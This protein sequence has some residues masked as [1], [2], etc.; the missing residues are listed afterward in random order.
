[1]RLEESIGMAVF[2]SPAGQ[3]PG[4]ELG[5]AKCDHRH[6]WMQ[7]AAARTTDE[8]FERSPLLAWSLCFALILVLR[9]F[10]FF[11][12]KLLEYASEVSLW[13]PAAAAT[14]ACFLVFGRRAIPALL[15]AAFLSALYDAGDAS[16]HARPMFVVAGAALYAACHCLC[17]AGLAQL[18]SRT[19]SNTANPS[20]STTISAFLVG[21]LPA[22]LLAGLTGVVAAHLIGTLGNATPVSF[23]L[24]WMLGDYVGLLTMGPLLAFVMRRAAERMRLPVPDT[25]Y[26]YDAL[27]RVHPGN[28]R[29][30][31][32][33]ASML[34]VV[35]GA[36]ALVAY[37]PE[38]QPLIFVV[39]IVIVLMLWMAV[40][41]SMLQSMVLIALF[42]LIVVVLAHAMGLKELSLLLQCATITLAAGTYFASALPM[43][44][45]HNAQLRE[46]LTTD[47]L[48]GAHSRMFFVELAE[49]A[50]RQDR[51]TGL[52]T[53][54]LM[55]DMDHLK[56]INDRHG[57]VAGD[58]ALAEIAR[59][60]R[61]ALGPGDLMGRLGGDEFCV[62]LPGR[63][64]Q[65]AEAMA[66]SMLRSVSAARYDFAPEIPPSVSIGIATARDGKEDY[67]S[68]FLRADSA[69]YV[70]K[71]TGRNRMAHDIDD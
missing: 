28:R 59:L 49:Q 50:L 64:P 68:L 1:M 52:P 43:L 16:L 71:R 22:T 18:V 32:R 53:S 60:C 46:I 9:L 27:H 48:T 51:A 54:M 45:A 62:L 30:A 26:A 24:P 21:G 47:A 31:P 3:A 5:S 10:L 40:D 38:Y 29:Y 37:D 4:A 20:I 12:S 8:R 11:G 17:Y 69:L 19:V 44:Y 41:Q 61:D 56:S 36:L 42:G 65:A 33:L 35:G 39:F 15:L 55:L 67:D 14:F 63:D 6:I 58:R 66:A 23:V 7:E 70:A 2:P 57:H 34:L 13:F 25:L